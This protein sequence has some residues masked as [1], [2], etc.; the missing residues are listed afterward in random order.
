MSSTG[1]V[2][3]VPPERVAGWLRRFADRHGELSWGSDGGHAVVD[4]A[5]GARAV[6][7]LPADD[8]PT[9]PAGADELGLRADS[10]RD[11]AL[12]LVRRGGYAVGRVAGGELVASR[13]GTRYVRGQT[14]AGGWSQQRYARRRANQ[15]D[16]LVGAAAQATRDVLG[17]GAATPVV[18][19]G[20][21]TLVDAC[22]KAAGGGL[23]D[24]VLPDRLDVP[25]PR[26][27]V[28]VAAVP[29]ARAVRVELNHL[30]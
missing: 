18:C 11:F 14:K 30:A 3:Q 26:R 6:F 23:A 16:E 17:G 27:R 1:R 28:L 13:C 19:G 15:A 21:R 29:Q 22:L 12:V 10:F 25:D 8:A 9:A 4:A 5:D 24:R 20:D 7:R 2:V